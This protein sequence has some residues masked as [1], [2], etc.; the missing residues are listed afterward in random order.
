MQKESVHSRPSMSPNFDTV[1]VVRIRLVQRIVISLKE[2]INGI[3]LGK[4]AMYLPRGWWAASIL[5]LLFVT[6]GGP[7]D[8]E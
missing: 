5:F 6:L 1:A 3:Q 7:S 4:F 2:G 8:H